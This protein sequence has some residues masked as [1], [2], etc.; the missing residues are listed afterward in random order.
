MVTL[1][2]NFDSVNSESFSMIN[3]GWVKLNYATNQ[4]H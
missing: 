3:K 2:Y 1:T 4:H